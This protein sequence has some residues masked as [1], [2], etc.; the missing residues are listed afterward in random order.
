M[1]KTPSG[2]TYS[3]KR[4]TFE[5]E[6]DDGRSIRFESTGLVDSVSIDTEPVWRNDYDPFKPLM[7]FRPQ[8]LGTNIALRLEMV[9]AF[10]MTHTEPP[11]EEKK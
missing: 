9:K 11:T 2:L 8:L 4:V 7:E 5:V 1:A 3:I 6:L 10:T